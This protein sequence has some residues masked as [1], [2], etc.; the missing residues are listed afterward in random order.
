MAR[1][2]A[3]NGF[4][5]TAAPDGGGVFSRM[6][7]QTFSSREGALCILGVTDAAGGC[8]GE[9]AGHGEAA[10]CPDCD[11]PVPDTGTGTGGVL[12]AELTLR[13]APEE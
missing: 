2:T 12:D 1:R 6:R 5:L 7:T 10:C 9:G 3:V 4:P 13:W 8:C 11:A